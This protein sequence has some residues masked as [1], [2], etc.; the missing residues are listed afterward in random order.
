MIKDINY[1]TIQGWMISRLHLVGNELLI[2][3]CIYGYC[4]NKGACFCSHK[5]FGE[6]CGGLSKTGVVNI[7]KRLL[8]AGLITKQVFKTPIKDDEGNLI[9]CKYNINK[10]KLNFADEK[11]SVGV[12]KTCTPQEP[13]TRGIP[14]SDTGDKEKLHRGIPESD[15]GVYK[16]VTPIL[17]DDN[18]N[19]IPSHTPDEIKENLNHENSTQD[20]SESIGEGAYLKTLIKLFGYN[21]C[22]EPEPYPELIRNM[23]S[24]S[25]PQDKVSDYLEW[26]YDILRKDCKQQDKFAG[27]FYRSF[28]RSYN[29]QLFHQ[30]IQDEEKKKAEKALNS[31]HCPVCG[32]KHSLRDFRCPCCGCTE[33]VFEN[34]DLLSKEKATWNL[35]KNNPQRYEEYSERLKSLW[36]KYPIFERIK[37]KSKQAEYEKAEAEIDRCYLQIQTA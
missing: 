28:T 21:P 16:K 14:E 25:V 8:E 15:T 33:D 35:Q 6:W 20:K 24:C 17:L 37:N 36:E 32:T 31:V 7:L 19:D 12:Q 30:K 29:I 13:V 26:I 34:E 2:Y 5:Y 10:E 11:G 9:Y 23:A 1:L 27:Y 3:S 22:F 18:A 4:Q